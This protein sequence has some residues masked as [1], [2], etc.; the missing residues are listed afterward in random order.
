MKSVIRPNCSSPACVKKVRREA[1]VRHP[2]LT[3]VARLPE[4]EMTQ[5]GGS[6]AMSNADGVRAAVGVSWSASAAGVHMRTNG[7]PCGKRQAGRPD[8]F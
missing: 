5:A 6:W 1:V 2:S 7:T 3:G 4:A 8:G